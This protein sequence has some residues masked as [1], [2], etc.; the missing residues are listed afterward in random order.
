MK[1]LFDLKTMEAK[2]TTGTPR[3]RYAPSRRGRVGVLRG[4][5]AGV[6]TLLAIACLRTPAV[7]QDAPATVTARG[8]VY[9]DQNGNR[10]FDNGDQ[11]LAGVAVSNGR[12]FVSSND[13]GQ[14]EIEIDAKDGVVFLIKPRDWRTPLSDDQLPLFYYLHKPAGS[15]QLRYPGVAPTGPLPQSV[16]FPLYPQEEPENFQVIL[17]GDTQARNE[18]EEGYNANTA[19]TEL[20]GTK[21]AFGV[22]LG[23]IVFDNLDVLPVHNR[24][25]AMLGVPWYNVIGNH[26]IN[27][28]ATERAHANETYERYYGPSYYS[29]DYGQVHFVVLDNID[30]QPAQGG[31]AAKYLAGFGAQQL[32][33]L[34]NDLARIPPEQMVVLSMHIPLTWTIDRQ[35]VYRLI[36]K[37]PLAL[38]LAAHTHTHEHY[39]I[40]SED[41][42]QGPVPHHHIINVTVCGSWWSGLKD[43]RG[44]PHALLADGT[45]RGYSIL[46][47]NGNDYVLDFKAVNRDANYQLEVSTTGDLTAG[48]LSQTTVWANVFNGSVRSKVTMTIDGNATQPIVLERDTVATDPRYQATYDRELAI[49]PPVEP[50]LTKPKPTTHLWK[51]PLPADLAAGL[52]LLTV[53]TTDMHGRTF[54]AHHIVQIRAAETLEN[55]PPTGE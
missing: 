43:E 2:E 29:F 51:A 45:P 40:G 32:E 37:R 17:F 31:E 50:A 6:A 23:D 33:F 11:P 47:F 7:G 26:D 1:K 3:D 35:D 25:V 39:F 8:V 12:E 15:P 44:F 5:A 28:D 4:V 27:Y 46:T 41:G 9:H 21:A 13:Q 22:T 49:Q 16:N 30:W 42:W 24:A 14:Y 38:S 20:L 53:E 36:E 10:T 54:A 34:K 19:I 55:S 52:H 48:R 18:T